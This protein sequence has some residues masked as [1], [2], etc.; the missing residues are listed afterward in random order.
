M[1]KI[2]LLALVL[3]LL[4]SCQAQP[5][6]NAETTPS[7]APV[8]ETQTTDLD[9]TKSTEEQKTTDTPSALSCAELDR[10]AYEIIPDFGEPISFSS[11]DK[12]ISYYLTDDFELFGCTGIAGHNTILAHRFSDDSWHEVN[13]GDYSAQHITRIT[14]DQENPKQLCIT[15]DGYNFHFDHMLND[16]ERTLRFDENFQNPEVISYSGS[17]NFW[18]ADLL[19][20][21]S[22]ENIKIKDIQFAD[23]SAAFTFDLA[24]ESVGNG[25]PYPHIS[26]KKDIDL[27]KK[28][29][30]KLYYI[31]KFYFHNIKNEFSQEW[32][33]NLKTTL[34]AEEVSVVPYDDP[35]TFEGTLLKISCWYEPG[36]KV[37]IDLPDSDDFPGEVI[38]TVYTE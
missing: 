3:I 23:K 21:A 10:I 37:K 20:V 18:E 38:F 16:F 13:L 33:D 34:N 14:T 36:L 1:K 8:E 30:D 6:E 24:G 12:N 28:D 31:Y 15:V 4:C 22:L 7:P 17:E 26:V 11:S 27:E 2:L 19:D 5:Q 32:I 35:D 29:G 25:Y 9:D